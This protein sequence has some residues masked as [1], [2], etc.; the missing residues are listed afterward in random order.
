MAELT[1]ERLFSDPPLFAARRSSRSSLRTGSTSAYLRPGDD[2]RER[3]DLW[4]VHLAERRARVL[5]G[6]RPLSRARPP[7]PTA[8]RRSASAG[9]SSPAASLHTVFSPCGRYLLLPAEGAGIL[10]T[11]SDGQPARSR[12]GYPAD[13]YALHARRQQRLLCARRQPVPLRP[14]SGIVSSPHR[15]RRWHVSYGLADFIAQEEMHRFEGYWW[16]ADGNVAR[17]HAGRRSRSLPKRCATTWTPRASRSSSSGIPTPD[18]ATPTCAYGAA[19]DKRHRTREIDYR[20]DADD[21]L[22]RVAGSAR[23]WQCSGRAAISAASI[24]SPST[25]TA[26]ASEILISEHSTDLGEPARQPHC[27]SRTLRR[28]R[29]GQ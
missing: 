16:S 19:F 21:Y 9:A 20:A 28:R 5:G 24:W 25:P 1:V 27:R 22:A 29:T 2:D 7:A 12:P 13:R 18:T 17:L 23:A 6:R 3:L 4:R 26:T 11:L 8:S 10:M 15:R 14:R